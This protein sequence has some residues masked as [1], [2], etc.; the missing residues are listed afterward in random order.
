MKQMRQTE[1][2]RKGSTSDWDGINGWDGPR[3]QWDLERRDGQSWRLRVSWDIITL[4][5]IQTR[6]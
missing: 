4:L 3:R 5:S 2:I 6:G 1:T